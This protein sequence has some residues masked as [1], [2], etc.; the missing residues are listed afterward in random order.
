MC[1]RRRSGECARGGQLDRERVEDLGSR[2]LGEDAEEVAQRRTRD[3][4]ERAGLVRI[5]AERARRERM[6]EHE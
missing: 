4:V 6:V 1:D 5:A 3:P 2:R